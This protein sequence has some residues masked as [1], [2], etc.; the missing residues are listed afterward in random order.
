M[1]I[2]STAETMHSLYYSIIFLEFLLLSIVIAIFS[3][4]IVTIYKLEKSTKSGKYVPYVPSSKTAINLVIKHHLVNENDVL[5]DIGCGFGYHLR[6]ISK[7]TKC[8][9]IVGIEKNFMLAT[10]TNGYLK[11]LRTPNVIIKNKDA[12]NE[13]YS[14]YTKV[15]LY[16]TSLFLKLILPKLEKELQINSLIITNT[17]R[18]PK[19][20]FFS[21]TQKIHTNDLFISRKPLYLYVYKKVA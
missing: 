14:K 8:K 4:V 21:L 2:T 17:F 6:K 1:I 7:E 10:L 16:M 3:Y 12:L 5:C 13:N 11:L 15:Y 18:L 9:K 19:S 20:K